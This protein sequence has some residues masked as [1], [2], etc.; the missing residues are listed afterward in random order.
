MIAE[1]KFLK[2]LNSHSEQHFI[3]MYTRL[4]PS[5]IDGGKI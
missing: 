3:G 4:L 2:H 1:N 5:A